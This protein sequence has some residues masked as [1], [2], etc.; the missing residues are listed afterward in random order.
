MGNKATAI[1][2]TARQKCV[3]FQFLEVNKLGKVASKT[4]NVVKI[5][6][7]KHI[8][9]QFSQKGIF[10]FAK[11]HRKNYAAAGEEHKTSTFA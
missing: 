10:H 1:I 9:P 5:T 4:A 2:N 6:V 7:K 3:F 8:F 11:I